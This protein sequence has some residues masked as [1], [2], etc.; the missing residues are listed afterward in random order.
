MSIVYLLL[1][2]GVPLAASMLAYERVRRRGS[3]AALAGCISIVVG[4]AAS[5]A[6]A[7]VMLFFAIT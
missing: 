3:G 6:I 5:F 1:F 7:S 2:I 4:V